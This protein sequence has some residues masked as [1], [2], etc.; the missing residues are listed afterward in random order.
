MMI[1][2]ILPLLMTLAMAAAG[3]GIVGQLANVQ[4]NVKVNGE[5]ARDGTYLKK[6]AVISTEEG[7]AS[8]MLGNETV[9]HLDR[10]AILKVDDYI[11]GKKGESGSLNLE[12]GATRTLTRNLGQ[13][14]LRKN[15]FIRTKAA[16]MGVR[17]TEVFVSAPVNQPPTFSVIRGEALI[18][19]MPAAGAPPNAQPGGPGKEFV[20]KG[21][22]SIVTPQATNAGSGVD[23]KSPVVENK[24][25]KQLASQAQEIA[26]PP[27]KVETKKEM[28]A[29]MASSNPFNFNPGVIPGQGV[30]LA[31]DPILNGGKIPSNVN[32][33]GSGVR[34]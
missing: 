19:L 18:Q 30:G 10:N 12:Q 14:V 3:E 25:Q 24:D 29:F 8:V 34:Y 5:P 21:G 26:P 6:G 22:Q 31:F 9:M 2:S 17:G 15:L 13:G 4:G 20:L 7:R 16:V 11:G 23:Q 33:S 27:A 1:H 32:I 28:D